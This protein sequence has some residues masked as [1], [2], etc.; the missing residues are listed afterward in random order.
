MRG[1]NWADP[2]E[3]V[4]GYLFGEGTKAF[5]LNDWALMLIKGLES[6][7][8]SAALTLLSLPTAE[9]LRSASSIFGSKSAL[10]AF[11][12]CE[13]ALLEVRSVRQASMNSMLTSLV[14]WFSADFYFSP[15]L[16]PS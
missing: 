11:T 1:E 2:N 4:E 12:A 16:M 13:Y 15:S 6:E 14:G 3:S 9:T 5:G 10:L 8:G 7:T